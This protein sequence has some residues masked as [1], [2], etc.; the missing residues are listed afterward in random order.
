[1]QNMANSYPSKIAS[2]SLLGLKL[3]DLSGLPFCV[4]KIISTMWI[5]LIT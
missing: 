5:Q 3:K 4:Q 2:T 1:M